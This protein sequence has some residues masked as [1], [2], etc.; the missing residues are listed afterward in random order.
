MRVIPLGC[1]WRRQRA[2]SHSSY[3]KHYG[4]PQISTWR[5]AA[6]RGE[7]GSPRWVC[8]VKQVM[9]SRQPGVGTT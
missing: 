1:A 8:K 5:H 6:C 4:I 7:G 9:D 2:L 3:C